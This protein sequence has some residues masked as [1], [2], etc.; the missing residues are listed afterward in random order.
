MK[1]GKLRHRIQL[2]APMPTQNS[3]GEEILSYSPL[4][5]AWAEVR[6][7]SGRELERAKV[8]AAEVSH[9][10]VMRY[11]T[12]LNEQCLVLFGTRHFQINAILNTDERNV[13]LRLLCT[14]LKNAPQIV[15]GIHI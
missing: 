10:V 13:E 8:V 14:E 11:M 1:A 9:E 3:T 2:L 6:P 15:V 7:L 5:Y 4:A 12:L